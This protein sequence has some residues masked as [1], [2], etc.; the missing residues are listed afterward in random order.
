MEHHNTSSTSNT[1]S[2]VDIPTVVWALL[3][4]VV[5]AMLAIFVFK[6]PVG[7]VVTYGF[8]SLMV[9]SHF[10]MHGRHGSH[11]ART[12][13]ADSQVGNDTKTDQDNTHTGHGGCH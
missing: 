6:V 9:L 2:Q 11:S 12:N 3:A 4:A 10:F 5:A 13:Q 1:A 8:L 7:T